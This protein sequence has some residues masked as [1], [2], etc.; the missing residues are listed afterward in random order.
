MMIRKGIDG[1]S[2]GFD[3]EPT[4]GKRWWTVGIDLGT[5]TDH[6]AVVGIESEILP[7]QEWDERSWKQ[8]LSEPSHVVRSAHRLKLR[9]DYARIAD[10][11][12]SLRDNEPLNDRDT[13]FVV[14]V[15]GV[16][17]AVASMLSER[18][19]HFEPV[20]WVAGD[21]F[22]QHHADGWRAGK[23][24]L[25]SH[26]GAA[27]SSNRLQI[28]ESLRDSAE[29]QKQLSDYQV[30]FTQAGNMTMNAPAGANDDMVSALAMAWFGVMH[31]SGSLGPPR[32]VRW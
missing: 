26:L 15:S 23:Q 14:D 30:Q 4:P 11:I 10:H 28:V 17:K 22:K 13:V 9:L 1:A 24:Y 32:E 16:G 25:M 21:S 12:A 27:L 19:L 3:Y 29:L 2:A 5:Q 18:G 6:T 8:R 31:C 20:T 7:L